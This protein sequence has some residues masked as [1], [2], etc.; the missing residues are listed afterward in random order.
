MVQVDFTIVMQ[1]INFGILLFLLYQVLYRPILSFLDKRSKTI[2]T[3]I[4]EALNNKEESI[5]LKAVYE[6]KIS[7]IQT[8]ADKIFQEARKTAE[9]EKARIIESAQTESKNIVHA[10]KEE[11]NREAT[12]AKKELKDCVC[13]MVVS[14]ASKVLERE[15]AEGDHKKF[16]EEF[17][18]Q[19]GA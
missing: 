17:V 13:S 7:D 5:E 10:A 12:K 1:W 4:E 8:E 3:H 9:K 2:A 11:I 6:N 14:C 19:E 16:I 18:Q 15:V